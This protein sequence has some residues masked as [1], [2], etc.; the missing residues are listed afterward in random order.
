MS[1]RVTFRP[2]MPARDAFALGRIIVVPSRAEAM[3][4]IVL[5][6][7]A[8]GKTMI[9]TAVGG[10][11]EVLEPGSPAL[12]APEA[13]AL[14]AAV[15]ACLRDEAAFAAHMPSSASLRARF[16]ADVMA[17]AIDK[18]YRQSLAR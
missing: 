9:G 16:G 15:V 3:P 5:E 18:A 4:Y 14:R 10:I 8:A 11:P 13:G 12:V 17:A 6:A 7:L 1:D 2:P